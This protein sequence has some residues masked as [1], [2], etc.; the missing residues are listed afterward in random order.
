MPSLEVDLFA[1]FG[2]RIRA[3]GLRHLDG[4]A[5]AD[6]LV[7]QV[8][9]VVIESLRAGKVRDEDQLA[10]FVLGTSRMVALAQ[11]SR[12]ARHA[13]LLDSTTVPELHEASVDAQPVLDADQLRACLDELPP[14]ERTVVVLTFYADRSGDEIAAELGT[15][16]GNVRVV[17]HRAMARL[18]RC[19]GIAE[20]A[21]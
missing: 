8:L 21:S 13:R 2:H 11:R 19:M 12:E 18:Q 16:S 15:T 4:A 7:Q 10:S 17:R 6:D 5:A 1:R 3:F 14:K 20:A 9:V